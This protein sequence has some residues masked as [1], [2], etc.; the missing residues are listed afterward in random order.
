M[1]IFFN[2]SRCIKR[3]KIL[4]LIK[5]RLKEKKENDEFGGR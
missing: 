3:R 4:Y 1:R 2:N 5:E